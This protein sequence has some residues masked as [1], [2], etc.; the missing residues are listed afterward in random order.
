VGIL[1][2]VDT[3][4]PGRRVVQAIAVLVVIVGALLLA[5]SLAFLS[6]LILGLSRERGSFLPIL[7]MGLL[8]V[9]LLVL[10]K[11]LRVWARGGRG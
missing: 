3:Q 7:G 6:G 8:G 11:Q 2:P 9:I 4:P 1:D 10:G 5:T